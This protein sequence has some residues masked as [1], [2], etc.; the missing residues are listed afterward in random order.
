M[1]EEQLKELEEI[2]NSE[3]TGYYSEVFVPIKVKDGNLY[4]TKGTIKSNLILCS[5]EKLAKLDN[6]ESMLSSIEFVFVYN[7]Q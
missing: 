7:L 1:E 5:P 2:Y 3:E 6:V 4:L